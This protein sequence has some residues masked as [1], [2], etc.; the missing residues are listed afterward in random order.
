[1]PDE[2]DRLGRQREL[3][4]PGM[5]RRFGAAEDASTDRLELAGVFL[6]RAEKAVGLPLQQSLAAPTAG[7]V[8]PKAHRDI[9]WSEPKPEAAAKKARG[10]P[11]AEGGRPWEAAGMSR[12]TWYRK[13]AAEE[14]AP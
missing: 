5:A 8:P 12:R 4:A 1:V 7:P 10:R 13:K 3:G 6:A 9:E 11:K 14:G 2:K